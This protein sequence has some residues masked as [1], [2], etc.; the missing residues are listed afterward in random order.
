MFLIFGVIKMRKFLVGAIASFALV[1][2]STVTWAQE[3][4]PSQAA[5]STPSAAPSPTPEMI[6]TGFVTTRDDGLS[7]PGA[8]VT[9][10]SLKLS[11]F[12]E[13]H[14]RYTLTLPG[15]QGGGAP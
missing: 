13:M 14:G 4:A 1:A 2:V 9:I 11:T 8:T 5:P 10:D 6:V 3:S 15:D 12:S 7:V